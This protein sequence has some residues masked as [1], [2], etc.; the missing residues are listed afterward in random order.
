MGRFA[1]FVRWLALKAYNNPQLREAL[2]DAALKYAEK[3]VRAK[4]DK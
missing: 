2:K 1:R 4:F 3:E